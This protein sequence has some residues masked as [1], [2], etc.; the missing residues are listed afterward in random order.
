MRI[1]FLDSRE[2][3]GG[4]LAGA[5]LGLPHN[6]GPGKQGRDCLRLNVGSFLIPHLSHRLK[7]L[8]R[9]SQ[10]SKQLLLHWN[11]YANASL[12]TMIYPSEVNSQAPL[13][14]VSFAIQRP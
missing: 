1:D 7:Q 8:R 6:I 3:K 12:L 14:S 4:G 13:V 11:L 5:R 2:R 9:Q 10:F